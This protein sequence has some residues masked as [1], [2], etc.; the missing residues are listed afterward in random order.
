M[1]RELRRQLSFLRHADAGRV[2][3]IFPAARQETIL[4]GV[5]AIPRRPARRAPRL[6]PG[7]AIPASV[8]LAAAVLAIVLALVLRSAPAVHAAGVKFSYPKTGADKGYIVATVTDPFAAQASLDAAFQQA[9]LDIQVSLVAASP[10][11]VGTVVEISEPSNGPQIDSLNG[12]SCVTGG[13]SC[14]IGVKIPRDFTGSGYITLGR[15]AQPGEE[16]ETTTSS[17]APGEALHCSGLIGKTY[18]QA[19]PVLSSD[20]ITVQSP[21]SPGDYILDA[22]PVKAGEIFLSVQSSPLSPALLA[23]QSQ[24]YDTGCP[25]G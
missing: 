10:S 8:G 14:P 22:N 15:P 2:D 13:G 24:L 11:L 20:G 23:R 25:K 18:A 19:E 7:V 3:E 5:V 9:G 1:T 12:G 4:A 17:F 6:R 21:P 16:Y